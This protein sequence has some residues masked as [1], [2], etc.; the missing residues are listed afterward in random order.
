MVYMVTVNKS[1]ITVC[2]KKKLFKLL[3]YKYNRLL[4]KLDFRYLSW[5][6]ALGTHT[7][8]CSPR[9]DEYR[10]VSLDVGGLF[11]VTLMLVHVSPK[12]MCL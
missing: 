1:D 2:V 6:E 3:E 11:L 9:L 12:K 5:L 4:S 7:P 8:D 10:T